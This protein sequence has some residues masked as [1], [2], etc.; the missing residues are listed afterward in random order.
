MDQNKSQNKLKNSTEF[1]KSN[2][3]D[4]TKLNNYQEIFTSKLA[5]SSLKCKILLCFSLEYYFLHICFLKGL[6][7]LIEYFN[8]EFTHSQFEVN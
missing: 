2:L 8:T 7:F 6:S 1:N 4:K 3:E 5:I